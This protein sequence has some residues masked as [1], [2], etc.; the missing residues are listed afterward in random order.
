MEFFLF[1]FCWKKN[2]I[3][4]SVIKIG[5]SAFEGCTTLTKISISYSVT[6]IC[7][8]AFYQCSSLAQVIIYSS[9][10]LGNDVFY[11]YSPDIE[12]MHD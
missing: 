1:V 10:V 11:G 2:E 5:E 12:I 4:D 7:G 9:K 6:S 8:R 3:S